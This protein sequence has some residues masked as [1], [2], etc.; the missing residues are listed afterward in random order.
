MQGYQKSSE[1]PG[2]FEVAIIG[3]GRVGCAIGRALAERGHRIVAA[4]TKSNASA[5]RVRSVL[6][7]VPLASP[8]DAALAADIVLISVPDDS[9][10]EVASIV[11][12]G[13]R[14]DATVVHTS[15]L[16]GIAPIRV[17]GDRVAAIHPAQ[18]I[19]GTE[20]SLHG[21]WFAITCSDEMVAWSEWFVDQLGGTP[22]RIREEAR[23]LYHAALSMASNFAVAIAADAQDLL[24]DRMILEPLLR[25]TIENI[26]DQG[27]EAALTGPIVR[28]DVGT[29]RAHLEVIPTQLLE[30]YVANA[31]RALHHAVSSGRLDPKSAERV[32]AALDEVLVR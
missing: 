10:E 32:R 9:I 19:S 4:S 1:V 2:A 7:D 23:P 30:A 24:P 3:A 12:S 16:H 13:I 28:G 21:V 22:L 29:V 5:V 25:Q 6:G 27:A 31:R 15:G 20:S 11:S 14:K 8:E 26:I 17:C 18:A